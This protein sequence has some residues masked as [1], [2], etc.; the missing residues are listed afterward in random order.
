MNVLTT[1]DDYFIVLVIKHKIR[2][3]IRTYI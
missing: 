1:Y 2:G 3:F